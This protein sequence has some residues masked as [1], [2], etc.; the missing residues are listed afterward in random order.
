M[1]VISPAKEVCP[2]MHLWDKEN[3]LYKLLKFI[4]LEQDNYFWPKFPLQIPMPIFLG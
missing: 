1:A 2:F 3:E 4:K